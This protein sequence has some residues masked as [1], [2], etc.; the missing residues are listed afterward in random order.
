MKV[1]TQAWLKSAEGDM[2]LARAALEAQLLGQ[3]LFH[4]EQAVEKSL[5][6]VWIERS[7]AGFPPRSH[8]LSSLADD[9]RLDLS[10]D[11]R[12]LL[13]HLYEEYTS[14]RYPDEEAEYTQESVQ[15]RYDQ[16]EELLAWLRPQLS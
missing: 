4:C 6:A 10:G 7:E 8:D 9:V 13:Q 16:T 12:R 3:C 14:G 15:I 1:E 5:K 11:Q 2:I